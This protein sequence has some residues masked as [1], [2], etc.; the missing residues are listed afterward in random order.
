[1]LQFIPMIEYGLA[2]PSDSIVTAKSAVYTDYWFAYGSEDG[3]IYVGR[4]LINKI[5]RFE[6]QLRPNK[7]QRCYRFL[8]GGSHCMRHMSIYGQMFF[9]GILHFYVLFNVV[10][11]LQ[12]VSQR[13]PRKNP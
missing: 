4:L 9:Q 11:Q 10:I 1:M 12:I 8:G 7:K 5:V 3:H 6:F 13:K 2:L